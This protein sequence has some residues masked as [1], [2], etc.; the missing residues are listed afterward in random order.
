MADIPRAV[1]VSPARAAALRFRWA[2]FPPDVR[3]T[4][5]WLVDQ[6]PPESDPHIVYQ[7]H[8]SDATF[9]SHPTHVPMPSEFLL[10]AAFGAAVVARYS[11][12]AQDDPGQLQN[13][14]RARPDVRF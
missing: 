8:N 5:Q 4:A 6:G 1:D 2:Q 3:Y 7:P 14:P 9:S 12:I 13:F 10:D 11:D